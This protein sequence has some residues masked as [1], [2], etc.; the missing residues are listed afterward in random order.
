MA[1]G[2]TATEGCFDRRHHRSPHGRGPRPVVVGRPRASC[3]DMLP[4][5][6]VIVAIV[7][8]FVQ[9]RVPVVHRHANFASFD[10]D[11]GMYDQGIWQ[12]AHGRSFMTVRGMDVFGAA[13]QP[14]L[15]AVRALLLARRRPAVPRL[16]QHARRHAVA[17]PVYLLGRYHLR[18]R[19]AGLLAGD[20]LPRALLTAVEDPGDLPSREPR[21]AARR[22]RV[23]PRRPGRAGAGTGVC[24]FGA[25]IWKEDVALV[26]F[27]L[28]FL[29]FFMY[30]DRWRG[31]LTIRGVG[32]VPGS[33]SPRSSSC[34][35]SSSPAPCSTTSSAHSART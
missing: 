10:Y 2:R 24:V 16:P 34:P 29:V 11:L 8:Y 28:G 18:S 9:S 26:I 12:F 35:R 6:A 7:A 32:A 15:P 25:I 30:K 21:R 17:V 22:R 3:T 19:W 31:S 33:S 20:R 4:L 13:R 1:A 14:R 23:L 5:I 27:V